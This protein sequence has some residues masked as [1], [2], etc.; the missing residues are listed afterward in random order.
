MSVIASYKMKIN[1]SDIIILYRQKMKGKGK[2]SL[3]V[4]IKKKTKI[5]LHRFLCSKIYFLEIFKQ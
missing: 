1:H 4:F 3:A 2:K 5:H